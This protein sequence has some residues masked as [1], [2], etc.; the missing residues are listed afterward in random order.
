MKKLHLLKTMLLL[1]ALIVG[2]SSVWADTEKTGKLSLGGT[3]G[4]SGTINSEINW[5][6]AKGKGS[7]APVSNGTS[8]TYH[9]I[10][11]QNTITISAVNPSTI[12]ITEVK[13]T[14]TSSGYIKSWTASDETEVTVSDKVATWSGET[15]SI[16]LTNTSG[17]QARITTIDITYTVKTN[18]IIN[19]TSPVNYAADITS[20]EIPYTITNPVGGKTLSAVKNVDWIKDISVEADKVTFNMDENFGEARSGK[21]TL[22]YYNA[23]DKEIIVNQTAAASKYTVTIETPV[24]GSLTVKRSGINVTSGSEIS[25]GS[26]LDIIVTPNRGYRMRN[27]Q[28]IDATTHT[29]TSTL[30]YE[31]GEH[32]V[33]IKANFDEIEKY[34]VTLNDNNEILT[35]EYGGEGV[36]LPNRND[37]GTKYTFVGWSETNS[38]E[39]SI[40]PTIIPAGTYLPTANITLYSVYSYLAEGTVTRYQLITDISNVTEGVYVWVS[41]KT[42]SSGQ[43][44]VYMPNTEASGSAPELLEG[45]TTETIEGKTYLTND[46]AETMLWD[47]TSTGT[48][49]QYY[50]RPHGS[51]T[52]GF[53]CT[54]TT[55]NNIRISSSYK[56]VK[57][58][59]SE[60]GSHNWDFKNNAATAMYLAVYDKTKWRNYTNNTTNQNGDFYLFKAIEVEGETAFYTSS[61]KAVVSAVEYATF[62]SP[63]ATDFS[64]TGITV[65]TAKDNATSVTLNEVGSGQVPANTPVVLYKAGADGS[66]IDVPVISSAEA[67]D[68]NDLEVS[69]GTTAKGDGIYVLSNKSKGVGFYPWVSA[70]SLSAGKVFLRIAG[71]SAREFIGFEEG[72]TTAIN[73]ALMNNERMNNEVYNLN[74]QRVAQPTKGLYIV[75]GKKVM[76]K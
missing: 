38:T 63:Y 30:T 41:Q 52:I 65:Y 10:Y 69:D 43:P 7:N 75:N 54:T 21:V 60:N 59:I 14:S 57:W 27:W 62:A 1:C 42:T 40:A 23:T 53:G 48:E 13:L 16:T 11:A 2:S 71:S 73:A 44:L 45:I 34:V 17:G 33:T 66:A 29:Y 8:S 35:E 47:F 26:I 12:T 50:I 4:T 22:S 58:T 19:A 31:M 55:G 61:K 20:G 32:D 18:P 49:N 68:D 67:V 39:T 46:I 74:G 24:N 3:V 76:F 6:L 5:E 51:T 25:V 36:T 70:S 72:E 9:K 64:E 37:I 56:D 28:A 15:S